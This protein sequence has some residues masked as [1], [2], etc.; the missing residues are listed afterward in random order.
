MTDS[1]LQLFDDCDAL[2]KKF[3]TFGCDL[4]SATKREQEL[5]IRVTD[6]LAENGNR[7]ATRQRL[8]E[9]LMDIQVAREQKQESRVR[10]S[11]KNRRRRNVNIEEDQE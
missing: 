6:Y 2:L 4:D 11:D 10:M 8:I 3:K 5:R 9:K 1:L 7:L